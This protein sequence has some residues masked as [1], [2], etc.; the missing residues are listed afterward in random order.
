VA[1]VEAALVGRRVNRGG[2]VTMV[3]VVV[4]PGHGRSRQ[5]DRRHGERDREQNFEG[6]G[7]SLV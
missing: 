2:G 7:L 4:R 5:S 6:H 3:M 1:S